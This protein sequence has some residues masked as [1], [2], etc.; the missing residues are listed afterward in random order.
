M[1]ADTSHSMRNAINPDFMM[2]LEF[3]SE[4]STHLKQGIYKFD[5]ASKIHWNES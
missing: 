1:A 2:Q 4:S 3:Y 5:S